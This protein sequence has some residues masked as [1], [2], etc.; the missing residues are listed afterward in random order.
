MDNQINSMSEN[1]QEKKL[2]KSDLNKCFILWHLL[3]ESTL[4]FERLQAPGV[5]GCLGPVLKRLYGDD[6]TKLADAMTRHMEFFNTAGYY[7]GSIIMG[8]VC[9]MEEEKANGAPIEGEDITA[10]KTGLMGPLAGV[11]DALRQGTLIPIVASIAIGMGQDGNFLG[12][13]FYM[14]ATVLYVMLPC[15]WMFMTTYKKGKDVVGKIFGSGLVDKY[16]TLATAI[17]AITLGGLA[18]SVVTVASGAV[19]NLGS[20]Q[21]VLQESF[22]DAIFKGMLP[23]AAVFFCYYLLNKKISTTKII[24]ILIAVAVIGVFIGFF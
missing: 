21:M 17:G 8:L 24:L 18:A 22:F 4:S 14:V 15:Y 11:F 2:T 3:G 1:S 16:M 7:G 6:K 5:L 13:V 10:I 12:P 9:S 20:T 23:L 19:L